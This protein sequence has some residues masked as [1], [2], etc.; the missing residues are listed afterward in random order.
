MITAYFRGWLIIW[1]DGEN[2][3]DGYW[4]YEDTGEK[5]SHK[6]DKIRPCRKCNKKF[7]INKPDQC[8]G[9]LPGVKFACC[10]HGVKEQAYIRFTNGVEVEDFIICPTE[11][12]E[13]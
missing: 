8:L 12:I 7:G 3:S 1:K 13:K 4:F 6:K 11:T 9:K 10:G 2:D 5:V